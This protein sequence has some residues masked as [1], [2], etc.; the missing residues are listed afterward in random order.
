MKFL[1]KNLH[2]HLLKFLP[3]TLHKYLLK[4]LSSHDK[5]FISLFTRLLSSE[6]DSFTK[7]TSL[8]VRRTVL[9]IIMHFLYLR[10]NPPAIIS[11]SLLTRKL[12]FKSFRSFPSSRGRRL[13]KLCMRAREPTPR[14]LRN[15]LLRRKSHIFWSTSQRLFRKASWL[16]PEW[17]I[18]QSFPSLYHLQ[19]ELQA[20]LNDP[21]HLWLQP[22]EYL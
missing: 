6:A 1:H 16:D 20:A 11:S 3:N 19:R 13:D 14:W 12:S 4:F 22:R 5:N 7:S 15:F 18:N 21:N 17:E 10:L 9:A 2:K 8:A